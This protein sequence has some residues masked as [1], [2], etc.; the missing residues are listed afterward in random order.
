MGPPAPPAADGPGRRSG[1]S[2]GSPL[3]LVVA[4]G[5]DSRV[6]DQAWAAI[7]EVFADVDRAMSR[8]SETS[9]ISRLHRARGPV[10]GVSRELVR[11]LVAAD[12]ARR[13]TNG[14]FDAR[15]VC[16]LERLGAPGV[17]VDWRG[18]SAEGSIPRAGDGR[19]ARSA[20][21]EVDRRT[22]A[23]ALN[24][25]VDLGGIGKG[26][27]LRWAA[28]DAAEHLGAVG[29]LLEAGGDIIAR[30]S[31]GTTPWRVAIEDPLGGTDPVATCVLEDGAAIATSSVRIA[32]WRDASGR[33]VHHL[34]DPA[35]GD[36]GGHGLAAVTVAW[37]DPA[38]AEVWSKALFLEGAEGIAAV[39]RRRDLAAWWIGSSGELSMT[40][41][42]RQR[43]TWVRAE[44]LRTAP[45]TGPQQPNG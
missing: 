42:A 9:E 7:G 38:W 15:V 14:R 25:P 32:R 29:F 45:G 23:V 8:F 12:R 24:A 3:R 19:D 20:L 1:R 11:A 26:L 16:D 31:A 28:D 4:P 30:G 22:G 33:P 18:G 34:I 17:P 5:A 43:T 37:R 36:P 2:L 6:I 41:A 21:V 44:A 27:A 35:T 10:A 40:P 13:V 39:A